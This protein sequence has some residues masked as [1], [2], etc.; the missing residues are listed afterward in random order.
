MTSIQPVDIGTL[1]EATPG[2]YGGRPC[3]AGT[4]FPVLEVAVHF[5]EGMPAEE[6][7]DHFPFLDLPRIY[8]GITY[9]LANRAAIDCELE[10]EQR[11]YTDALAQ[12][13]A[14]RARASA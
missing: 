4:R 5:K 2:I 12:D 10:Q 7:L 3:L 13:R 9:Y 11:D 8:A 6:M 14:E 1:I